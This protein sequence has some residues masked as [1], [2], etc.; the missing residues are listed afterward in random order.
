MTAWWKNKKKQG[1]LKM[2]K[3]IVKKNLDF[4]FTCTVS[5]SKNAIVDNF[6]QQCRRL[7]SLLGQI[8]EWMDTLQSIPKYK[9]V[10]RMCV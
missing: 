3:N 6:I 9:K 2:K 8:I 10:N 1:S 4:A 7:S 5:T